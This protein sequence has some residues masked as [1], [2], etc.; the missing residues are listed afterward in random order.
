MYN[1]PQLYCPSIINQLY[2]HLQIMPRLTKSI[3]NLSTKLSDTVP[4]LSVVFK[5]E[6]EFLHLTSVVLILSDKIPPSGNTKSDGPP[7]T[8][9]EETHS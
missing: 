7:M 2:K 8:A 9:N 5:A 3:I 1:N 4:V 6:M